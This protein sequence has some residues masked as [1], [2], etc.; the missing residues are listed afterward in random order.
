MMPAVH[1][2]RLQELDT[3]DSPRRGAGLNLALNANPHAPDKGVRLRMHVK[4]LPQRRGYS[5]S[6]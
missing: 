5:Q 2:N 1:I 3:R 4:I 6:V